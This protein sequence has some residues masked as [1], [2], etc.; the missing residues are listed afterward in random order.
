MKL[1]ISS[2]GLKSSIGKGFMISIK[3]RIILYVNLQPVKNLIPKL[4]AKTNIVILKLSEES[5]TFIELP[6]PTYEKL[7]K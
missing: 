3:G 2:F 4:L 6:T 1:I 7:N 5:R